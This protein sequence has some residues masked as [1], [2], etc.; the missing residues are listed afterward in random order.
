MR[1]T[2]TEPLVI[3]AVS[4]PDAHGWFSLGT[5]SEYSAAMI[6]QMP[7]FLEVNA[8][9]PRTLGENQVHISQILDWCEASRRRPGL[10]RPPVDHR[11]RLHR[12]ARDCGYLS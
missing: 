3:V 2:T 10:H 11:R 4:P 1:G 5:N 7:F 6:G 12:E 9:M 8:L